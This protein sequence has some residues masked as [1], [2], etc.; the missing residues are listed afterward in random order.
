VEDLETLEK[1]PFQKWCKKVKVKLDKIAS[2]LS[3]MKNSVIIRML[4]KADNNLYIGKHTGVDCE[5][6]HF[7]ATVPHLIFSSV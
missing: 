5:N 2:I 6:S 1:A 7:Q 4:S 3:S